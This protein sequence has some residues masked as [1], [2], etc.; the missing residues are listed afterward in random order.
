MESF[1]LE[2]SWPPCL[3][4]GGWIVVQHMIGFD[5]SAFF[6]FFSFLFFFWFSF[7]LAKLLLLF[8]LCVY[9]SIFGRRDLVYRTSLIKVGP[10]E[11]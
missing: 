5:R 6:L 10:Y 2:W 7:F 11:K 8:F 1:L 9:I 3:A 4:S